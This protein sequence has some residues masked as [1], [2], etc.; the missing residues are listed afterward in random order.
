MERFNRKVFH[1]SGVLHL[2]RSN[3]ASDSFVVAIDVKIE[4]VEAW[5]AGQEDVLND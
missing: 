4:K 2:D 1:N 3:P 5:G